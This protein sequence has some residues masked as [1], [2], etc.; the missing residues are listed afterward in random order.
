M[1]LR[2]LQYF[3]AVVDEG[4]VNAAAAKVHVAQPSLSRQIRRLETELALNLFNRSA[5]RLHLTAAGQKFVP[6]ARDLVNRAAQAHAAATTMSK[7]FS[8]NLTMASSPTTVADIIS[9]FIVQAG[10]TGPIANVVEAS[11]EHVYDALRA[12]DADLAVGTRVPPAEL[13][14]KVIGRAYLWAQFPAGHPLAGS[15]RVAIEEL[16]KWPLIVQSADHGVRRMFDSAA[17]ASGLSYTAAFETESPYVAQALA[18]AGR[19][20]CVLSD[21]SRYELQVAP[22]GVGSEELVITLYGVWDPTH[23]AAEAIEDCLKDL[24]AFISELYPQ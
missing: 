20:V 7:G 13:R 14:S 4:S 23:F 21:D 6:I 22:I 16:I 18:A 12:G 24:G 19:G 2:L 9:P 11:P 17:T 1:D 10:S 8:T 5:K 3:L 15:R